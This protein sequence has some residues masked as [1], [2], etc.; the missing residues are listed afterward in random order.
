[1]PSP[2]AIRPRRSPCCTKAASSPKARWPRS[3]RTRRSSRSTLAA[4]ERQGAPLLRVD[5]L[6][7]YYGGSHI[8]RNVALEAAAG[9][10]TVILGRNGVGKTT[11][12]K[13]RMGVAP[14]RSGRV[15]FAGADI[16]HDT[17]YQRARLGIGYVPQGREIF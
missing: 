9:E 8:L 13:R 16:T 5:S 11:W 15:S 1:M 12:M 4:E 2:S 3:R 10:V 7:Q 14:V 6:D 17:P